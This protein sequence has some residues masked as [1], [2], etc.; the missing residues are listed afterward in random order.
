MA[1]DEGL[2]ARM[3][4]GDW[5]GEEEAKEVKEETPPPTKAKAPP[6]KPPATKFGGKKIPTMHVESDDSSD[7]SLHP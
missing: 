6:P 7:G 1:D 3:V 5:E 2:W 4:G